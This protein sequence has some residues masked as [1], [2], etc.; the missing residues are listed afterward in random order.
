MTTIED[1][2]AFQRLLLEEED[3]EA[4]EQLEQLA[5]AA[6]GLI[7]YGV[8]ESRRLRSER[9]KECHVHRHRLEEAW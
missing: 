3:D 7:L 1:Y 5:L 2:A 4:E 9:R 6:S 8:E